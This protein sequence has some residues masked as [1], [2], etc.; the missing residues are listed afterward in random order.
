M[1]T[2]R[3]GFFSFLEFT[4]SEAEELRTE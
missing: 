2:E 4:L 1:S 3:E